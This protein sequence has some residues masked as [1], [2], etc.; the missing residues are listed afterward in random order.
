M[1]RALIVSGRGC[2]AA[3]ILYPLLR[4]LEEGVEVVVTPGEWVP[5]ALESQG[6]WDDIDILVAGDCGEYSVDPCSLAGEVRVFLASRPLPCTPKGP[7]PVIVDEER[8]I[9]VSRGWGSLY[10]AMR[11]A[12]RLAR[13]RGLLADTPLGPGRGEVESLARR[14]GFRRS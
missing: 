11:E 10:L 2:E 7:E 3:S 12:L 14:L 4:L 13:W 1:P 5:S 6:P 8:R 9:V